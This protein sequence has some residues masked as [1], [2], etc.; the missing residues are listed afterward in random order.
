MA[1]Q[2]KCSIKATCASTSRA[3]RQISCDCSD[4]KQRKDPRDMKPKNWSAAIQTQD[5]R[6]GIKPIR[7]NLQN[8]RKREAEQTRKPESRY[9]GFHVVLL[10]SCYTNL[11]SQSVPISH[12]C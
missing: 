11:A 9:A 12:L 8:H 6:M 3:P 1:R 4:Q 2:G 7:H 10:F 5:E